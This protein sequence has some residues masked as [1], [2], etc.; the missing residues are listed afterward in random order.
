MG[1]STVHSN[2]FF[3]ISTPDLLTTMTFLLT[4]ELS[5]RPSLGNTMTNI[6]IAV[7]SISDIENLLESKNPCKT[8]KI[9][10]L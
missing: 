6:S 8:K 9:Q 10:A 2:L 5:E 3:Y 1:K 4:S 7:L